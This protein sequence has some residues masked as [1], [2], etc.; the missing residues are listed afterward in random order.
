[1]NTFFHLASAE[2]FT[3]SIRIVY[4]LR[5]TLSLLY[6]KQLMSTVCHL[7]YSNEHIDCIQG[8]CYLQYI[9]LPGMRADEALLARSFSLSLPRDLDRALANPFWMVECQE[10]GRD[11]FTLARPRL[12]D[13]VKKEE[14]ELSVSAGF[15]VFSFR[16]P[17][18]EFRENISILLRPTR[19]GSSLVSGQQTH[20]LHFKLSRFR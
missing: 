13:R 7:I 8:K 20:P 9:C 16:V 10:W 6:W 15:G 2:S 19:R 14:R 12:S 18:W 11:F 17:Y 4:N 3:I 5:L 1:M